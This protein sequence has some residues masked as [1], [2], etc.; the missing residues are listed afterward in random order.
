MLLLL[1]LLLLL[2]FFFFLGG[3]LPY[4]DL[5]KRLN[6]ARFCAVCALRAWSLVMRLW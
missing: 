1:L 5:Y 4:G 3:T 2:F 6:G